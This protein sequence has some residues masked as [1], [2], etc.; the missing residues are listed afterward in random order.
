M[1]VLSAR[2]QKYLYENG[3][4]SDTVERWVTFGGRGG[5]RKDYCG[6][7][8]LIAFGHGRFL[9]VQ[10][11]SQNSLTEH[12]GK[13]KSVESSRAWVKNGGEVWVFAWRKV[14]SG[15]SRRHWEPRL[16]RYRATD[17]GYEFIEEESVL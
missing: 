15:G 1:S 6:F 10:V 11:C 5:V 9:A 13:I 17:S 4:F 2:T 12:L 3:F 7:A 14:K 8:D 16:F